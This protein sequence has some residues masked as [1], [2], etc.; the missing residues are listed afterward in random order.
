MP[1][2]YSFANNERRIY[3]KNRVTT[4]SD[5]LGGQ[6]KKKAKQRK[7]AGGSSNQNGDAPGNSKGIQDGGAATAARPASAPDGS[8][9]GVVTAGGTVSEIQQAVYDEQNAQF[10]QEQ[11]AAAEQQQRE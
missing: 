2:I 1:K 7:G 11:Q 9:M 3:L 4:Q 10:L 6:S 5:S 8:T